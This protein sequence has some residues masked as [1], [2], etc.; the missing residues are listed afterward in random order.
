MRGAGPVTSGAQELAKA[1]DGPEIWGWCAVCTRWY[2]CE[3]WFDRTAPHPRCP[4]CLTEPTAIENRRAGTGMPR[5]STT[6]A[7]PML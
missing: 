3:G 5:S 7:D 1:Q 2:F 4:V 6:A